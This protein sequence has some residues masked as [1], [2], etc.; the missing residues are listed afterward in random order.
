MQFGCNFP[1]TPQAICGAEL[2][3]GPVC[4]SKLGVTTVYHQGTLWPSHVGAFACVVPSVPEDYG[5]IICIDLFLLMV[6]VYSPKFF[7]AFLEVLTD[8]VTALV[9]T[10]LRVS[11][12]CA[13]TKIPATGPGPPHNQESFTH[14]DCYIYYIISVVK[15]VSER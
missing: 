8:V 10:A 12:Y 5:I 6:W 15:F 7:C 11:E 3:E 9:D 2:S 13:I 14:I 4:V 1:Y